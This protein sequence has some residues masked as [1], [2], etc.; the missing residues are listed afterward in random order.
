MV[1]MNSKNLLMLTAIG[2]AGVAIFLL[3]QPAA[4]C[5]ILLGVSNTSPEA[6]VMSRFTGAA[7]LAIAVACWPARLD[8]DSSAQ[9]RLLVGVFIYDLAAATLLAYAALVQDMVGM[10][11]WPAVAIHAAL[12]IWCVAYLRRDR[13]PYDVKLERKARH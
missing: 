7:I 12:A 8:R 4:V 3:V 5:S 1:V 9:R 2:E 10:A 6:L 11:L 13:A